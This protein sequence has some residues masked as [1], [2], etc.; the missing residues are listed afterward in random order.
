MICNL[1]GLTFALFGLLI[2]S[3]LVNAAVLDNSL[4][5]SDRSRN[6]IEIA[7]RCQIVN[8]PCGQEACGT[9]QR[10]SRSM[11]C[12]RE[13]KWCTKYCQRRICR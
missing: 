7:V 13:P 4:A 12:L 2:S 8:V 1:G 5:H 3:S 10:C 9:A 6:G 11:G